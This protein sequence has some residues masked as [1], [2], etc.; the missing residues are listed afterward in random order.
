[1]LSPAVRDALVDAQAGQAPGAASLTGREFQVF[2]GVAAGLSTGE[3]A[4]D[5]DVSASTVRSH[6]AEI[7]AKL[8]LSGDAAIARYAVDHGLD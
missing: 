8:T 6:K 3:I 4:A 7:R 1:M 5:L 2:R